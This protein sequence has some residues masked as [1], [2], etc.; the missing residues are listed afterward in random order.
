MDTGNSRKTSRFPWPSPI[1]WRGDWT[2]RWRTISGCWRSA[3]Q[4]LGQIEDAESC[5]RRTLEIK[6]DYAEAHYN[7]GNVLRA[8]AR[9]EE[10]AAHYERTLLL[11]PGHA[12]AHNNLAS[13]LYRLAGAGQR[14][15]AIER[16][17][18]WV[19]IT[20]AHPTARHMLA[21]L[22]GDAGEMPS[23]ASDGYVTALFDSFAG[24]FDS[25]LAV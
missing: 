3:L 23:R 8:F 1:T 2:R 16:A 22:A 21:A 6:L 4:T 5:F 12:G 15:A 17:R 9:L 13:A 25:V 11:Q 18:A 20:P 10:A 14:E 24:K 19:R 7:L